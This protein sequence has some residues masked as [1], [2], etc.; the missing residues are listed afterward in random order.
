MHDKGYPSDQNLNK[1]AELFE[2]DRGFLYQLMGRLSS[3]TTVQ[4]LDLLPEETKIFND[5][6]LLRDTRL[7]EATIAAIQAVLVVATQEADSPD[8]T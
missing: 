2:E 1:L 3:T 5:L 8:G 7:Y 4:N 6:I